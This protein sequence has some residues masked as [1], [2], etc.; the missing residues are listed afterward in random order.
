MRPCLSLSTPPCPLNCLAGTDVFICQPDPHQKLQLK[1]T[2]PYTMTLSK[3]I[4]IRVQGFPDWFHR[5]RVK[6]TPKA[7]PPS[8]TLTAGNILRVPVYDNLNREK[9]S[10]KVEGSQRW[11]EDEWPPQQIIEYYSPATCSWGYHTPIYM[12]NRIIKA[13]GSSRDNH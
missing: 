5:T 2:D 7:T 4:A 1:W 13:T 10:L 6:L 8:K 11:Q 12:L 3:P 9:Q